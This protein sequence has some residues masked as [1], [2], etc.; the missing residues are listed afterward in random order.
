M[1]TPPIKGLVVYHSAHFLRGTNPRKHAERIERFLNE[2]AYDAEVTEL[3]VQVRTG[4]EYDTVKSSALIETFNAKW[5]NAEPPPEGL[6]HL[7]DQFPYCWA[8]NLNFQELLDVVVNSMGPRQTPLPLLSVHFR[9]GF[10][11]RNE[12]TNTPLPDQNWA[13]QVFRDDPF[14]QPHGFSEIWG[15]LGES[16]ALGALISFP[17]SADD[18]RLRSYLGFIQSNFPTKLSTKASNWHWWIVRK[19]G[20]KH[21]R[22]SAIPALG[23]TEAFKT[24]ISKAGAE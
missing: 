18:P 16:S 2:C 21:Y 4:P 3:T 13:E 19:D 22:R 12:L 7:G 5:G 15:D 6:E 17:F 10:Q 9:I 23:G 11:L 8:P 24:I 1:P 14:F 20:A